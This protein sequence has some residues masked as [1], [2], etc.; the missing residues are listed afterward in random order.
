MRP[1][2]LKDK[3]ELLDEIDKL[4]L[5]V[6]YYKGKCDGY[7]SITIKCI[8]NRTRLQIIDLKEN[9]IHGLN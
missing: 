2:I 5:Q 8:D 1:N 9:K 6:E 7:E 4:K 3:T